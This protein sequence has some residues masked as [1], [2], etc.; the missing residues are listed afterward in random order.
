MSNVI[1]YPP[2]EPVPRNLMRYETNPDPEAVLALARILYSGGMNNK[3]CSRPEAVAARIIAGYEVGLS[4]VQSVNW[5][6]IIN[7]RAVIWGD[8]ALA[9]VRASGLLDGDVTETI[10]GEGDERRAVCVT[11]RKGASASRTTTFSVADAK[12][13]KLWGKEGPWTE[14]PD[15][16]LMWRAR[17]WNL[18]DNFNDV[19]CGLGIAEEELDVP[20]R[21]VSVKADPAPVDLPP[22]V[23]QLPEAKAEAVADEA[24]IQQIASAR[25]A[26]LRGK[27]IDPN[28]RPAVDA[29][30]G[31][32]LGSYGVTSAR[33]LSP[34]KA[35]ELRKLLESEG[36]AQEVK[37]V[38]AGAGAS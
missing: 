21:V 32:L 30:W 31:A 17:G 37:E 13:A 35:A 20:V 8:A 19:L 29:A 18:R 33:Q 26:W 22:V 36:F 11:K 1:T 5:I 12:Q 27:G 16:Q 2:V 9:L 34:E 38:F 24:T 6:A 3:H 25:P 15:R 23:P 4:P 7:G 10:E 14:Y 28:D